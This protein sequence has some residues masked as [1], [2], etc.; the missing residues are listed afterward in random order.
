MA[1]TS[2]YILCCGGSRVAL[3]AHTSRRA[4]ITTA[5]HGRRVNL[6]AR[7]R[8]GQCA[9]RRRRARSRAGFSASMTRPPVRAVVHGS[10][11]TGSWRRG[12]TQ[13][14]RELP[15]DSLVLPCAPAYTGRRRPTDAP[16]AAA[17]LQQHKPASCA[18]ASAPVA[19]R[20]NSLPIQQKRRCAARRPAEPRAAAK[21]ALKRQRSHRTLKNDEKV[22][23]LGR[24][25]PAQGPAHEKVG[26]LRP[27]P[28]LERSRKI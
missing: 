1:R 7:G 12:T 19:C 27:A 17:L 8:R 13:I 9:S 25:R 6:V 26:H 18:A 21:T 15:E 11:R 10:A 20:R 28:H 5:D 3:L 16:A 14:V 23:A 4:A 24:R 2:L 22:P